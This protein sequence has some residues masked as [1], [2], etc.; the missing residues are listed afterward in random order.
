MV[1]CK[2]SCN[3]TTHVYAV[4]S[5]AADITQTTE[6]LVGKVLR[7][8]VGSN[9]KC[10]VPHEL[11][12][13]TNLFSPPYFSNASLVW[14]GRQ[15]FF[16]GLP[17]SK[18]LANGHITHSFGVWA[19]WKKWPLRNHSLQLVIT[20]EWSRAEAAFPERPSIQMKPLFFL[21]SLACWMWA[22]MRWDHSSIAANLPSRNTSS[23]GLCHSTGG[24]SSLGW[25]LP[26]G[27][28]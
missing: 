27:L 19:I 3:T 14:K 18:N 15:S 11:S 4:N 9:L 5:K 2:S 21:H 1:I 10:H 24:W 7:S 25:C 23:C 16:Y 17:N 28:Y 20:V 13:I 26:L 22:E 12:T 6:T 8:W